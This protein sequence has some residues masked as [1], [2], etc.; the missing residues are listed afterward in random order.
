[1][2]KIFQFDAEARVGQQVVR[3]GELQEEDVEQEGAAQTRS[4]I[5][6]APNTIAAIAYQTATCAATLICCDEW[7]NAHQ[8]VGT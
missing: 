8:I 7:P 6:L 1:M 5:G 3:A 4:D 2:L